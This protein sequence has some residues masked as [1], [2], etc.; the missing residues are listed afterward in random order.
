MMWLQLI[1]ATMLGLLEGKA[2][3]SWELATTLKRDTV[4]H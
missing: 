1:Q 3:A 4:E 2:Q